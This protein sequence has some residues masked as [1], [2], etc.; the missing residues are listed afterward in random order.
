MSDQNVTLP[1]EKVSLE[2]LMQAIEAAAQPSLHP[3]MDQLSD[4]R[5]ERAISA[6]Q[7]SRADAWRTA[8]NFIVQYV[9]VGGDDYRDFIAGIDLIR[10]KLS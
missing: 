2:K 10:G 6:W 9:N 8:A 1:K 3:P 7:K 4:L 5:N